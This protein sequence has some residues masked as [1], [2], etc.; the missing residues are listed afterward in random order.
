VVIGK[1]HWPR[2]CLCLAALVIPGCTAVQSQDVAKNQSEAVEDDSGKGRLG[3][4]GFSRSNGNIEWSLNFYPELGAQIDE[5]RAE[6]LLQRSRWHFRKASAPVG[7]SLRVSGRT[8][9][10]T[11]EGVEND[12]LVLTISSRT[13]DSISGGV[14]AR[15]L[16]AP[17]EAQAATIQPVIRRFVSSPPRAS[18]EPAPLEPPPAEPPGNPAVGCFFFSH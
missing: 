7:S 14:V 17:Q 3:W 4:S 13:Q 1:K 15:I 9:R 18:T 6:V 5:I 2:F 8:E 11:S 16:L 10:I 12:L